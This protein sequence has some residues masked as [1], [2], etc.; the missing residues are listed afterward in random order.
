MGYGVGGLVALAVLF[1]GLV[2]LSNVGLRGMRAD[3]TQNKLYTLSPGTQ[4]VLDHTA[5]QIG[6]YLELKGHPAEVAGRV[7]EEEKLRLKRRHTFSDL[8]ARLKP[9]SSQDRR[10][11]RFF[12]QPV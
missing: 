12:L 1:L 6:L 2:M 4:Q 3:L 9:G 11:P 10:E 7:V 8:A 5:K